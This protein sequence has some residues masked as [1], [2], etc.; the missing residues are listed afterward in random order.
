[1]VFRNTSV[2]RVKNYS[3][4][5]Y[6]EMAPA[7]HTSM[8]APHSPQMSESTAAFPSSSS[9]VSESNGHDKTHSPHPVH[10]SLSTTADITLQF[11]RGN[12]TSVNA[13]TAFAA[14][15]SIDQ[16]F[17]V[18]VRLKRNRTKRT[19]INTRSAR[20]TFFLVHNGCHNSSPYSVGLE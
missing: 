13:R 20:R 1:M 9:N 8:H 14:R 16:R 10:F 15:R 12:R 18:F 3:V 17:V 5:P 6:S 7:G 4:P 19:R 2:F 11:Y